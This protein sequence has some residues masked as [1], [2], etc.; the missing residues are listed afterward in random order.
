[1]AV[2]TMCPKCDTN[3]T[4]SDD[5]SGKKIRCKKCAEPFTV[6]G[7][8]KMN[9][10][11]HASEMVEIA[12]PECD[13]TMK[14]RGESLGKRVKCKKCEEIFTAK[15]ANDEDD[16]KTEDEEEEEKVKTAVTA[17][18]PKIKPA[19]VKKKDDQDEDDDENEEKGKKGK[20]KKNKKKKGGLPILLIAGGGG[21]LLLLIALAIGG[22][23]LFAG[24][25]PPP[26]VTK[27]KDKEKKIEKI[28]PNK[29]KAK[30]PKVPDEKAPK[31]AFTI[32]NDP[33]PKKR[34]ELTLDITSKH[35]VILKAVNW[36]KNKDNLPAEGQPVVMIK[37]DDAKILEE[38][39]KQAPL[40]LQQELAGK[41]VGAWA[42]H[43]N[44]QEVAK[45]LEKLIDHPALKLFDE[46]WDAWTKWATEEDLEP[47]ALHITRA[48]R[49]GNKQSVM[50]ALARIKTEAS[51]KVQAS[52]LPSPEHA[53][54]VELLRKMG[55]EVCVPG[56]FNYVYYNDQYVRDAAYDLLQGYAIH[57]DGPDPFTKA[58]AGSMD[59]PWLELHFYSDNRALMIKKDAVTTFTKKGDR[60]EGTYV[61]NAGKDDKSGKESIKV[62][63]A[64][65]DVLTGT[66][67]VKAAL[68][69]KLEGPSAKEKKQDFVNFP[70]SRKGIPSIKLPGEKIT[71][72]PSQP[73]ANDKLPADKTNWLLEKSNYATVVD[74]PRLPVPKADINVANVANILKGDDRLEKLAAIDFLQKAL[75]DVKAWEEVS[76]ALDTNIVD[77]KDQ[78]LRT[79]TLIALDRWSKEPNIGQLCAG[80][81]K[82]LKELTITRKEFGLTVPVPADHE[83]M[84]QAFV[85]IPD[86]AASGKALIA[87]LP[88]LY[89]NYR[90]KFKN[91]LL[92]MPSIEVHRDSLKFFNHKESDL[93]DLVR[94]S[95]S[96]YQKESDKK[97]SDD[98]ISEQCATDMTSEKEVALPA[99]DFMAGT[100]P[101]HSDAKKRIE[102]TKKLVPILESEDPKLA[103]VRAAAGQVLTKYSKGDLLAVN[104]P[105][106][107]RDM[108]KLFNYIE[109]DVR[110]V[111]RQLVLSFKAAKRV[112]DDEILE[113]CLTDLGRTPN[114][115]LAALNWVKDAPVH[116]DAKKREEIRARLQTIT[117]DVTPANGSLRPIAMAT[118]AKYGGIKK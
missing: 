45:D 4:L 39:L 2:Q 11:A 52:C 36:F 80:I 63:F 58:K 56:V 15:A 100:H 12:C 89:A 78:F 50:H 61:F 30:D 107:P 22:Y 88:D 55:G 83:L 38:L 6:G 29:D 109:P 8:G 64:N 14:V 105:D 68:S 75:L 72:L 113:Q 76:K 97:L 28:D 116:T 106:A 18:E 60:M 101:I 53:L 10:K 17:K 117:E 47:L 81:K 92:S 94:L 69:C 110:G 59:V 67:G 112:N 91:Y 48:P 115:A 104:D 96:K 66:F 16:D 3:H 51:A 86:K 49:S 79:N 93:R 1:M 32:K 46:T 82:N 114:T 31:L 5:K 27:N 99:L 20:K 37:P 74:V 102:I 13:A 57:W 24:E 108:L 19:S 21:G 43:P 35:E 7:N 118:I 98:E 9:G 54:A 25:A 34:Q 41:K 95:I 84:I 87:L 90:A 111:A 26:P 33:V 62:T 44:R 23:F 42:E 85:K 65:G 103:A 71:Y 73:L 77:E 70:L 40:W